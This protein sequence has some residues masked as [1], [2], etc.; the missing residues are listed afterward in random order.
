[1]S[2]D[3]CAIAINRIHRKGEKPPIIPAKSAFMID[4]TGFDRLF[5]LSAVRRATAD[6][7][8]AYEAEQARENG[9]AV[10]AAQVAK[11]APVKEPAV[12][13][14]TKAE[15]KAAA[16]VAAKLAAEEAEKLAADEE[17]RKAEEAAA[18]QAAAAAETGKTADDEI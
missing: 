6:E 18:A 13:V 1:M 12:P 8:A 7:I 5:K 15:E 11:T 3:I 17:A 2:N 16:K 9:T 4:K 14:L 10:L